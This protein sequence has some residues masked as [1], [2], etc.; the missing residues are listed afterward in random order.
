MWHILR[1]AL[2][3]T[4]IAY[5]GLCAVAFFLQRS[6]IYFPQPSSGIGSAATMTLA[7]PGER[8]LVSTLPKEGSSAMLYFGGNAEDVSLN[9]PSFSTAFPDRA[10]YLMHYRGYGGSSGKP[11]ETALFADALALYDEVR[12][13]RPDI[14]VVGRSLGSGVAIYVASRRPVTKLVLVAP[15]D[16]I[17]GIAASQFPYLPIRW[18]LRDRFESGTYARSVDA[19]TLILAA[20][21]DE[22]IPRASTDLLRSRFRPGLASLVVLPGT[23]H[24]TISNSPEYLRLL[25]GS[26]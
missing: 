3:G 6:F 14:Q 12:A 16:S 18:L 4:V 20:E 1:A 24:N 10:V 13:K 2:A 25:S 22:I 21:R 19:P 9:I 8:V 11:S 23:G 17:V 5:V 7:V 26:A 15:F